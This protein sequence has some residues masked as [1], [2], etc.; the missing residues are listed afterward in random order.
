[1]RKIS[2]IFERK[3]YNIENLFEYNDEIFLRT[4][5]IFTMHLSHKGIFDLNNYDKHK[6]IFYTGNTKYYEIINQLTGKKNIAKIIKIDIND[7][8]R[9]RIFDL[10]RDVY[11]SSRLN[12]PS[13][14]KFIGFS[15]HDFKSK[16]KPV[17]VFD[18][19]LHYSLTTLLK[20]QNASYYNN[21][22]IKASNE[23]DKESC[24]K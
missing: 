16:P 13:F 9:I 15:S 10:Y 7:C 4:S 24:S 6:N 17:I 19:I 22:I 1:M 2:Q 21:N 14:L 8:S 11:I 20:L 3:P 18:H 23:I 12:H 5:A